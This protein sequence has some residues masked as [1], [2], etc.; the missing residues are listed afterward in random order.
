MATTQIPTEEKILNINEIF[1]D[2]SIYPRERIDENRVELFVSLMKEGTT[3]PNIIIVEDESGKFIL[4][5][6]FHRHSAYEKL[7]QNELHCDVIKADPKLW[8]LLSVKFNFNCSTPLKFGEIKKAIFNAWLIDDIKDKQS[9]AD[10]IGCTVQWVRHLTRDMDQAEESQKLALARKIKQEENAS[11]RDI[12]EKVGLSK[13]TVHRK[14]NEQADPDEMETAPD[15]QTTVPTDVNESDPRNN[16]T[17]TTEPAF[18]N[19]E[20]II[21]N[22]DKFNYDWEPDQKETLYA[23]DG[24][25]MGRSVETISELSGKNPNWIRS[26]AYALL[27]LH[28]QDQRDSEHLFAITEKLSLNI[29]RVSFI[30]YLFT[31]WLST[32]PERKD[33]FQWILNNQTQYRDDRISEM[34]RLEHLYW[35]N[36]NVDGEKLE[37]DDEDRVLR[38][39]PAETCSR[40]SEINT[41]FEE[42]KKYIRE[43]EIETALAKDLMERLNHIR[44]PQNRIQDHLRKFI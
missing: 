12:A 14:L 37:N 39:L 40:L 6:G 7:N 16:S 35:H 36:E 10:M 28:H 15:T 43:R 42:L 5:D 19:A 1:K 11:I 31:H 3:F 21:E 27:A 44:I 38:E 20:K 8:R 25:R 33:L 18:Q 34:V 22:F 26:T 9:I 41:Y 23:F 24:I 17:E 29:E 2:E 30:N 13:S 32:L 4:L